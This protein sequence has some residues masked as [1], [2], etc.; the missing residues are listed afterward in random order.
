MRSAP[1]LSVIMPT[2]QGERFLRLA[3]D[4]VVEQIADDVELI[5]VDDGS[6]DGTLAILD[7]FAGRIHLNVIRQSHVGNWVENTNT[8]FAQATGNYL[9]ML[10]QD[11]L[12]LPGRIATMRR[13]SSEFPEAALLLSSSLYID[14]A[15]KRLGPWC[16]P[17]QQTDTPIPSQEMLRHLIVQNFVALPSPIFKREH[18][19]RTDAMDS[20]LWFLADWKLWGELSAIGPVVYHPKAL[21]AFRIHA[22]SQTARRTHDED[23]LR[24]QYVDVIN[25]IAMH[26][27]ESRMKQRAIRAAHLNKTISI[28]LALWSHGRRTAALRELASQFELSPPVWSQFLRDSRI[29]ERV[30]ARLRV[31]SAARS[32]ANQGSA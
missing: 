21:T 5:A 31:Q 14:D 10:H 8:G 32:G 25:D 16:P 24:A 3:L 13:L 17:L 7:D 1:W 23:D 2:Y 22:D 18:Y 30:G 11:D 20:H 28:A 4:S 12:W 19:E 29:V 26:L 6:T 27:P 9:C 15:G